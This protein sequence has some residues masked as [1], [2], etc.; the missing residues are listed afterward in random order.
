MR[1]RNLPEVRRCQSGEL[2]IGLS[3][4]RSPPPTTSRIGPAMRPNA[5]D[6][7]DVS[8]P[9]TRLMPAPRPRPRRDR[10]VLWALMY[11]GAVLADV[12]L[13]AFVFAAVKVAVVLW[14]MHG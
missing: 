5:L 9:V 1:R 4:R 7:T 10:P 12:G 11:T 3:L 2:P 13:A 8:A 6:D 14:R